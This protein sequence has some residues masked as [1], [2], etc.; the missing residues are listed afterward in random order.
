MT[1]GASAPLFP[2]LGEDE[3]GTRTG[4]LTSQALRALVRAQAITA[5]E[6]IAP[7]QIQPASIDLRLGPVAYR[8]RASFL[9]GAGVAVAD[10][11]ERYGMHAFELREGAVL[12]KGCVYVVPLLEAVHLANRITGLGN[13]KSSTGRLDVFTRL[14]SDGGTTFDRIPA[15]YRG[16]LYAEIAPRTFSI[17]LRT[18]S[19][20]CQLRLRRG[21]PPTGESQLRRLQD[22]HALVE[23]LEGPAT[24]RDDR[25]AVTLD[26]APDPLT[27]VTGFRARKHADVIDIDA[28]EAYEAAD[29]W[30][31]IAAHKGGG[32]VLDPDDFHV[33]ATRERVRVPPDFAAEMVAYD[34]MVGEF[35]VH[36]AGFFDPGF[37][38]GA[39]AAA[40]AVLEVRSHDVP[41]V[42]EHGQ[43]IGWLRYERLAG[44]PDQLYGAAS[45][46]S[47]Q[48]QG[49][50]LAKQF[51]PWR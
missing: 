44:T 22:E 29:F 37:G 30:E 33:L 25:I 1:T 38:W 31:P 51:R 23:A 20:L 40:K 50:K 17:K 49:L 2:A 26:L 12:E 47:Y 45:G 48:G 34:T 13:P 36:Y 46:A 42:L 18:G 14:I 11:L 28:R 24:I 19:R 43:T 9:P 21:S 3:P 39:G 15:G 4:I 35:R 27:K 5:A 32:L 6:P 8:I 16:P 7:D 10:K 41:F